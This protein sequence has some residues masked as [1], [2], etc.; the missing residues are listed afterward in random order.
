MEGEA[1]SSA[2]PGVLDTGQVLPVELASI[3]GRQDGSTAILTWRTTRETN[4]AGFRV[5]RRSEAR[6]GWTQAGYVPSKAQGG[7]TTQTHFYRYA[8]EDL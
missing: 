5:Q 4:S 2:T 6:P 7:A 1:V 8:V 3:R